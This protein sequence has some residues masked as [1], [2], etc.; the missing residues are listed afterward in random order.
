MVLK[1]NIVKL[2]FLAEIFEYLGALLRVK[3]FA[4]TIIYHQYIE[5]FFGIR[6]T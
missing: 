5:V 1:L 4:F 3:D 2:D 6:L